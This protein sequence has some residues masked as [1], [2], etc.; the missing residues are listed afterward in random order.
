MGRSATK[1]DF[2]HDL[3]EGGEKQPDVD[4]RPHIIYPIDTP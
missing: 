3:R 2:V 1:Y 4:K